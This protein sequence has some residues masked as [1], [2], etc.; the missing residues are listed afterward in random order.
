[1]TTF[2]VNGFYTVSFLVLSLSHDDSS[3]FFVPFIPFLV[4]SP[5]WKRSTFS[6]FA[7][8][9]SLVVLTPFPSPLDLSW[10]LSG[11][12]FTSIFF[13]LSLLMCYNIFLCLSSQISVCLASSQPACTS[14]AR[15]SPFLQ[16]LF[17]FPIFCAGSGDGWLFLIG[18]PARQGE[19]I[20]FSGWLS[21]KQ[22]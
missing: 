8:A 10:F 21:R 22:R 9:A 19:E 18:D 3:S 16:G 17:F 12:T 1:L 14:A 6:F 11:L 15:V 5:I 7:R 13:F 20:I 2:G 4:S